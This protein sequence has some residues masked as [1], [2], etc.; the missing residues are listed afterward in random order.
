MQLSAGNVS[1]SHASAH[2]FDFGFVIK[3]G[4]LEIRSRDLLHGDRNG[5]L[6]IP[7]RRSS[8]T[9][10]EKIAGSRRSSSRFVSRASFRWINGAACCTKRTAEFISVSLGL[11]VKRVGG[12]AS[13]GIG[14]AGQG[15]V[16]ICSVSDYLS[17]SLL[18]QRRIA[19][20]I[21]AF[22]SGEIAFKL[23]RIGLLPIRWR[24]QRLVTKVVSRLTCEKIV[25]PLQ[26]PDFDD[27]RGTQQRKS[28][29]VP[30]SP[31]S[32]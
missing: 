10:G 24:Q 20:P 26:S 4:G 18:K 31:Q 14:L 2:M 9:G 28:W 12:V 30:Q 17:I 29:K 15:I 22:A 7:A 13:I 25:L 27:F 1:V 23:D 16:L 32:C 19:V 6:T 3:I 21:A 11:I 8:A 5:L